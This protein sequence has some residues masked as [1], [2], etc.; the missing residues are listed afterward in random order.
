MILIPSHGLEDFPSALGEDE[1]KQLLD[2][3]AVMFHPFVLAHAEHVWSPEPAAFPSHD[4][5]GRIVLLPD[6]SRELLDESWLE[7]ADSSGATIL[8]GWTDRAE[9]AEMLIDAYRSYLDATSDATSSD[10]TEMES[11]EEGA[12]TPVE[13]SDPPTTETEPASID[14]ELLLDFYALGSTFLQL[15]LLTH[16]MHY[17]SDRDDSRFRQL[18]TSAAKSALEG[19][20]RQA[21]QFLSQSFEYLLEV[22]ERFHPIE[23]YLLDLCL[24]IPR[25]VD[26]TFSE[27]FEST[28]PINLL[29]DAQEWQELCQ[30]HPTVHQRLLSKA[31]KGEVSFLGGTFDAAT[32]ANTSVPQ[33]EWQLRHGREVFRE[34]FNSE[35]SVWATK[36]FDFGPMTPQLLRR[37]GYKAAL[38][39]LLANGLAPEDEHTCF[40]WSGADGSSLP[41]LSRLPIVIS[42][43]ESFLRLPELLSESMHGDQTAAAVFA[44]WPNSSSELYEDLRRAH[45]Y[46]PVLGKFVTFSTLFEECEQGHQIQRFEAGQ[47]LSPELIVAVAAGEKNPLGNLQNRWLWRMKYDAAATI[48]MLSNLIAGKQTDS[49]V[50]HELEDDLE[51]SLHWHD[52]DNIPAVIPSTEIRDRIDELSHQAQSSFAQLITG[53]ANAGTGL[54][55]V[56]PHPIARRYWIDLPEDAPLPTAVE[57]VVAVQDSPQHRGVVINLPAGGFV[58]TG[59]GSSA[60][61]EPAKPRRKK[62][63][64]A[65]AEENVLRSE[66]FEALIH[67]QTGGIAYVR[68]YDRRPKRFSQQLTYRFAHE[69]AIPSKD[70]SHFA[71]FE[72]KTA[73]AEQR[74]RS[75]KV[76]CNGPTIGEIESTGDIVDQVNGNVLATF[77]QRTRI[78]R[79]LR[80]IDIDMEIEPRELPSGD[81]WANYYT[82]RFAWND[83]GASISRSLRQQ[84][85]A[86]RGQRLESPDFI[87]VAENAELR[88]TIL[89]NGLPCHRRSDHR[90]LDTILIVPGEKSRKFKISVL[91][92]DPHPLA[93]AMADAVPPYVIPVDSAPATTQSAWLV[94]LQPRNVSMLQLLPAEGLPL[95]DDDS[96]EPEQPTFADS[97]A[98][99]VLE[100]EGIAVTANLQL[101][102]EPQRATR[103]DLLG[104][105]IDELEVVNGTVLIPM[106]GYE[107]ATVLL[108][109]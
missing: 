85:F 41:A 29:A 63:L 6:A 81:P 15:E 59:T 72:E 3:F 107:M 4:V 100:A 37:S 95:V 44:S 42:G 54:V 12:S 84:A 78:T 93:S 53:S 60:P 21:R 13:T 19:N 101:F 52:S 68:D 10:S 2:A 97:V 80:R 32:S 109:W 48:T 87:E 26:D 79:G 36:H 83:S 28:H 1:A 16:R 67:P 20:D 58:F 17:Y 99:R 61:P 11:S 96:D 98:V 49:T 69:R 38:H 106:R 9:L 91:V 57:P 7:T 8:E 104:R 82:C 31:Q 14:P 75:M 5:V 76:T 55:F 92:D 62:K 25:M 66:F 24:V 70:D 108:Q 22:R 43:A 103:V 51:S 94:Q 90:M 45:R 74:C 47:Y 88:T 35:P 105:V 77:T 33:A 40:Q 23:S 65:M 18:A 46:A 73:Y 27:N 50:L 71:Q 39:V 86:A 56:N 102:I 30:E 64:P 34:L 89:P